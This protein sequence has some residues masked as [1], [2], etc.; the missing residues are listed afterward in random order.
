MKIIKLSLTNFRGIKELTVNF[1][2]KDTD[3]YGANGT[4]KTTISNAVSWLLF[5]KAATGEKDFNPKTAG[6]HNLHHTAAAT[7]SK[8]DGSLI[9]VRKDFYEVWTKKKGSAAPT[10]SGNTTDYWIDDIPFKESAYNR[11]LQNLCGTLE[12]AKMLT[13]YDY[14]P[15]IMS[16]DDRRKIL[17]EVCGDLT[18]EEVIQQS[19]D[20]ADIN[21]YLVKPGTTDQKYT[22]DEYRKIATEQR[23]KIN[24]ELELLPARI[25]EVTKSIP[26]TLPDKFTTQSDIEA[27]QG[28]M[29]AIDGEMRDLKDSDANT[30]AIQKEIAKT[31]T[32]LAES[33]MA[34]TQKVNQQY[35]THYDTLQQLE[36]QLRDI[37]NKQHSLSRK[38]ESIVLEQKQA[39]ENR[40]K[41]LADFSKI[42]AIQW[43]AG[44]ESCPT[45]GRPL[46]KDQ[47]QSMREAFNLDKSHKLEDINRRGQT[48]SLDT[49]KGLQTQIEALEVNE[50]DLGEKEKSIRQEKQQ[51]EETIHQKPLF[52][53]SKEFSTLTKQLQELQTNEKGSE[54]SV[55]A[56]MEAKKKEKL[57]T[58]EQIRLK[59]A[60]LLT[61]DMAAKAT[62]RIDE[63]TTEQRQKA[64][65]LEYLEKGL[66]LCDE[67]VREKVRMVTDNINSR[68]S[69]VRFKLFD[70]QLNGGVKERCEPMVK[71]A[72]G[73][74]VEYRSANTAAQVNAGMDII[75]VLS[76]YYSIHLPVFI[77]RAESV[78]HITNPEGL[79]LIRLIVS[80]DDT[81]LRVEN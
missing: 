21:A 34:F 32:Q 70:E 31:Q 6:T 10:F 37:E 4:G 47:I 22:I 66:F 71:N 41:L 16:V 28:H 40:K 60:A 46:P 49:I 64:D 1:D 63:L 62:R 5:G 29:A 19:P 67:F 36:Q 78:T 25:D 11:T 38:R 79:Q 55:S 77:D 56:V 20:L 44:Q 9:T 52:E 14:F 33:K 35:Q 27:L 51:L 75:G 30:L 2:G 73:E 57:D 54:Q 58:A 69:Y 61:L 43:D 13:M 26:E 18:D 74:W 50:R 81:T 17:F 24:H 76:E 80:A 42:Q 59:N 7:F 39:M 8:D 65:D 72:A 48:C 15:E 12:A 3:I 68:F 45:C 53:T 23:R